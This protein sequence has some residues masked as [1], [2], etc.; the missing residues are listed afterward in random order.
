M[1]YTHQ[2]LTYQDNTDAQSPFS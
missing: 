1:R 2:K